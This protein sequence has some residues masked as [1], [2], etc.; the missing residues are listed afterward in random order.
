MVFTRHPSEVVGLFTLLRWFAR[1]QATTCMGAETR[2]GTIRGVVAAN[3]L[4]AAVFTNSGPVA[5]AHC[6]A[7]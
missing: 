7:V 2:G 5:A 3:E 1:G 4:L 6:A